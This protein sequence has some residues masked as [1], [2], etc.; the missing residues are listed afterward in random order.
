MICKKCDGTGLESPTLVCKECTG[1]GKIMEEEVKIEETP[2][3]EEVKETFTEDS[4]ENGETP[5]VVEEVVE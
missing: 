5:E 1:T 3:V 4:G 2:V